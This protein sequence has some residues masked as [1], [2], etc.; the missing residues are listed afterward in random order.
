[1]ASLIA[2]LAIGLVVAWV[3]WPVQFTNADPADLRPAYK[4]D[5]IRMI[6]AAYDKD[7]N[8]AQARR[9]LGQLGLANPAPAVNNLAVREKQAGRS[10]LAL[11]PLLSLAQALS[12][13]Q[14]AQRPTFGITPTLAASPML[15]VSPTVPVP[16]F[17]LA[18]QTRLT[19]VEEAETAHLR[20]MV[21]D[22]EGSDLPNIPIE[23]RWPNGDDTIYT[24]LKPERGVGYADYEVSP[25]TFSVTILGAR[26]DTASNLHV[27]AAPTDCRADRGTTTRGWRLIFQQQ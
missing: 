12:A 22:P 3:L 5:Y 9:R 14:V 6:G 23:I 17:R 1:V 10:L 8:L 26:S 18:E 25:D 16:S 27:G 15:A 24:G 4:D 7:G 21:R 11:K 20:I 13:P 2:G 19:C